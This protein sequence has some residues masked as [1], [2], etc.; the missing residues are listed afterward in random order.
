M[1]SII[2]STVACSII[3]SFLI[4][5]VYLNAQYYRSNSGYR[6]LHVIA[7]TKSIGKAIQTGDAGE[8]A[9][10]CLKYRYSLG[11]LISRLYRASNAAAPAGAKE[12][13]L[14]LT[15]GKNGDIWSFY[16]K[17]IRPVKEDITNNAFIGWLPFVHN[18]KLMT[19]LWD[20]CHHAE[21]IVMHLAATEGGDIT[22]R[23]QREYGKLEENYRQLELAWSRWLALN[24]VAEAQG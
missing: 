6:Q 12:A 8:E 13:A 23:D 16:D 7:A 24:K 10:L 18:V 19:A 3:S 11:V 9:T 21:N 5:R 20:I 14:L 1:F 22:G 2:L 15:D 17:H 4:S